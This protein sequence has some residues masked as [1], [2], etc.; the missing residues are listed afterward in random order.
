MC[1]TTDACGNSAACDFVVYVLTLDESAGSIL[2]QVEGLA[3][4][5]LNR[6]QARSLTAKLEQ[7]IDRFAAGRTKQACNMLR[8]FASEVTAMVSSG[9]LSAAD[10]Q[11]L[12]A[13]AADLGNAAGCR[14]APGQGGGVQR[15]RDEDVSAALEVGGEAC[16]VGAST[17]AMLAVMCVPLLRRRI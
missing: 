5:A 11:P 6:G 16:G 7:I 12:L 10:G 15:V 17:G 4:G 14:S 8:A 3:G 9:A 2:E 1:T 13:T